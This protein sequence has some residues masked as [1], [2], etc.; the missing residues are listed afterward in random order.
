MRSTLPEH[1]T[2]AGDHEYGAF[3]SL[4]EVVLEQDTIFHTTLQAQAPQSNP[5]TK[6]SST[7]ATTSVPS[8]SS[9]NTSSVLASVSTDAH[10]HPS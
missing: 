4:T 2:T 1:I 7:I 3:V 8:A 10:V 5:H 9:A 6:I